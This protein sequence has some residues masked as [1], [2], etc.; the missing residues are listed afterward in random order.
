MHYICVLCASLPQHS[1]G[2]RPHDPWHHHLHNCPPYHPCAD[3]D[4]S[5]WP[6]S[7]VLN[8][9]PHK[10]QCPLLWVF[11][12]SCLPLE[13]EGLSLLQWLKTITELCA[14]VSMSLYSWQTGKCVN[15]WYSGVSAPVT[16]IIVPLLYSKLLLVSVDHCMYL[17]DSSTFTTLWKADAGTNGNCKVRSVCFYEKVLR[18]HIQCSNQFIAA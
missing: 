16:S 2:K 11:G 14:N 17:L 1:Y 8:L 10:P 9:W 15:T 4:W 5:T 6:L 12:R 7:V 13:C 3:T 18:H